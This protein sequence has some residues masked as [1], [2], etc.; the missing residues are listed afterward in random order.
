MIACVLNQIQLILDLQIA[1]NLLL[2]EEWT[3][4]ALP[5]LVAA[6]FRVQKSDLDTGFAR[7]SRCCLHMLSR[8]TPD[9]Q[10]EETGGVNIDRDIGIGHP[11]VAQDRRRRG[12]GK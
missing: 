4:Q 7:T 2:I 11:F 8:K 9:E 12:A 1:S 10:L 6:N 3:P 5:R